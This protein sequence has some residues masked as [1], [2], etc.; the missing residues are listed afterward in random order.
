MPAPR[1]T[2][3]SNRTRARFDWGYGDGWLAAIEKTRADP[4]RMKDRYYKAGWMAGVAAATAKPKRHDP[5]I[6]WA[7][8]IDKS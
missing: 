1:A 2:N 7:K 6:A 3:H 5:S 8:F 4:E